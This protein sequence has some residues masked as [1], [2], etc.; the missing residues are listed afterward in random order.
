MLSDGR[1]D[2]VAQSPELAPLIVID[3]PDSRDVALLEQRIDDHNMS[4]TGIRDARLLAIIVRDDHSAVIA[5]LYGWTW[6]GC[7]EIQ[8]LWIHERW[9]R[10]QL[11]TRMM[12]AA[13]AE[14]RARGATQMVL[15]THSFQAPEFYARLGFVE[16]GRVEGYPAGHSSI[17][18][19]KTLA[20]A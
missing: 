20:G 7:C 18:L 6:G 16:V 12:E 10:H 11:G 3:A 13:E 17:H 9:R 15:S 8:T 1:S 5:G 4:T 2:L 19:R 14:A